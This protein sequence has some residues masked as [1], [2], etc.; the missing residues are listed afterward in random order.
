MKT[1]A[2]PGPK[3]S[4]PFVLSTATKLMIS[5]IATSTSIRHD[6][7]EYFYQI[8]FLFAVAS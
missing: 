1:L 8:R 2:V 5:K 3:M 6:V 4:T 7:I